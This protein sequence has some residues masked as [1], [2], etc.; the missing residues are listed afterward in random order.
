MSATRP[1][2]HATDSVR[3]RCGRFLHESYRQALLR[4]AQVPGVAV[5]DELA[6]DL[7]GCFAF[8][9]DF[10]RLQLRLGHDVLELQW[11]VEIPPGGAGGPMNGSTGAGKTTASGLALELALTLGAGS[12]GTLVLTNRR[13]PASWRK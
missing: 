4:R 13:L 9:Q 10:E 5:Q 2:F 6:K 11:H 8:A 12:T 1:R 3:R 7:D